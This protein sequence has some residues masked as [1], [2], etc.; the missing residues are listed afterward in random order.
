M[1]HSD[2]LAFLEIGGRPNTTEGIVFLK[3][4]CQWL[5]KNLLMLQ[6][7]NSICYYYSNQSEFNIG[8]YVPFL[9]RFKPSTHCLHVYNVYHH[10]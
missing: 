3:T 9:Y 2:A 10:Q 6:Q 7:S 8:T 5:L 4:E 1:I